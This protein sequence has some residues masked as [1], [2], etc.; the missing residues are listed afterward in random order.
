LNKKNSPT[1][2]LNGSPN[3]IILYF[4]CSL[5][6]IGREDGSLEYTIDKK[7]LLKGRK[8]VKKTFFMQINSAGDNLHN[9]F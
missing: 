4:D 5:V 3:I 1:S 2:F 6:K 9:E 7:K 8:I